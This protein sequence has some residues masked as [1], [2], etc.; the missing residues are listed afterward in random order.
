MAGVGRSDM[1]RSNS[2][3]EN[4]TAIVYNKSVH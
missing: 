2:P 4:R 3:E 1:Y